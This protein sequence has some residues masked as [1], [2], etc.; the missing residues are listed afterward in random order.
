MT[1]QTK[2]FLLLYIVNYFD[3]LATY[4]FATILREKKNEYLFMR[5]KV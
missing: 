1:R 5:H 3:F 4:N 2:Y